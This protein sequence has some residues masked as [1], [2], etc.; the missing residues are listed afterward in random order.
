LLYQ[1][2]NIQKTVLWATLMKIIF[3][4]ILSGLALI[5]C[6]TTSQY[7]TKLATLVGQPEEALIAK[8]G[9]PTGRYTDE[10]G[11]EVIAY[12]RSREV[13]VPST[14]V[15]INTPGTSYGGGGN[16]QLVSTSQGTPSEKIKLSCMTI[17]LIRN[18]I[19]NSSTFKGNDCKTRNW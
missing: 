17:F 4:S 19:V 8:W 14:S 15:A 7:Q 13:I 12:I 1:T 2:L 9:K 11:D 3:I 5:G 6:A 18:G 10:N 16:S